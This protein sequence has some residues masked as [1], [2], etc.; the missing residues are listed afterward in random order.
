MDYLEPR[1]SSE[2]R[3]QSLAKFVHNRTQQL[4]QVCF[5]G[6]STSV[7]DVLCL[8]FFMRFMPCFGWFSCFAP[9]CLYQCMHPSQACASGDNA[10]VRTHLERGCPPDSADYDNRTGLML[11]AAKGHAE[12][13][14]LRLHCPSHV[15]AAI[16]CGNLV[17]GLLTIR[18]APCTRLAGWQ[19]ESADAC[20]NPSCH[21]EGLFTHA[22]M[23]RAQVVSLLLGAG[24]TVAQRDNFGNTAIAEAERAG[25]PEVLSVLQAAAA[26]SV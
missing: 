14:C 24:A 6:R 3:Q 25:R 22:V 8:L 10:A 2:E 26:R 21:A 7:A 17:I 4:L 18:H 20:F 1:F 13:C 15:H 16:S 12:V 23:V 9:A 5:G 19:E 11:A